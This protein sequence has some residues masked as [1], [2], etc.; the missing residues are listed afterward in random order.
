MAEGQVRS[1]ANKR[2]LRWSRQPGSLGF[3]DPGR[4]PAS[5]TDS[6]VPKLTMLAFPSPLRRVYLNKT[7]FNGIS[8]N[9]SAGCFL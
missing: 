6:A 4:A 1:D 3:T 7:L 9:A 5:G 2:L 8:G